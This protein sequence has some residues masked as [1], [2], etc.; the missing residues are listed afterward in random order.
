MTAFS[1]KSRRRDTLPTA[2]RSAPATWRALA[3]LLPTHRQRSPTELNPAA[4]YRTSSPTRPILPRPAPTCLPPQSLVKYYTILPPN[5]ALSISIPQPPV[6]PL[7]RSP[8]SPAR[9]TCAISC[10]FQNRWHTSSVLAPLFV[11]RHVVTEAQ[12]EAGGRENSTSIPPPVRFATLPLIGFLAVRYDAHL[13]AKPSV[14]DRDARSARTSPCLRR[15][16][17]RVLPRR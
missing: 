8:N 13:A 2:C 17:P 4:P 14:E 7:L 15:L 16:T 11:R 1:Q 5:D 12:R 9:K 6:R 10:T 3:A